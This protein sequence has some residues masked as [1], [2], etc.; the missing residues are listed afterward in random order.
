MVLGGYTFHAAQFYLRMEKTCPEANRTLLKKL[1]LSDPMRKRM[2]ELFADLLTTTRVLGREYF[3]SLYG[4]AVTVGGRRIVPLAG[5]APELTAKDWLTFLRE[6]NGCWILPNEHRAKGRLYR[7]SRQGE[8]LLLDGAE[9]TDAE[10]LAFLNQLPDQTL[11]L[12]HIEPAGDACP[13]AE[14]PVLHYALLRRECETEEILLQWED[15]G[16]KKG[17][18][19]FSFSTVD[20][21]PDRQ[22]N[23]AFIRQWSMQ[24]GKLFTMRMAR[25]YMMPVFWHHLRAALLRIIR[26]SAMHLKK[27]MRPMVWIFHYLAGRR[28]GRKN[29]QPS[30]LRR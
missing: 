21:K 20:R 4:L 30:Q 1:L 12:E 27:R 17:Y 26:I 23:L 14:F 28:M 19:P 15:H 5:A 6:R 9:Q 25:R 22:R 24:K 2:D 13:E 18:S 8:M 3:P 7:I 11:L 16:N 10:L 29:L